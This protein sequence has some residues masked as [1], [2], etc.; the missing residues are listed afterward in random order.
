MR[1]ERAMEGKTVT[2]VRTVCVMG[3]VCVGGVR[4]RWFDR[5]LG[6]LHKLM[7]DILSR[8]ENITRTL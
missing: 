8:V 3:S 1:K 7:R 4:R 2:D 6:G 5:I